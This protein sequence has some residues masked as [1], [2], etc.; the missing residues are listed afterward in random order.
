[1]NDKQK[2]VC[3]SGHRQLPKGEA[4]EKLK[5][6]L[7]AEISKAVNDGYDTFIF[8]GAIGFDLL[9]G[10]ESQFRRF[11]VYNGDPIIEVIAV[12]PCLCQWYELFNHRHKG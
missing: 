3:F 5:E 6:R 7:K 10:R 2:T 4:L 11:T 12:I 1:M 8:G 9:C